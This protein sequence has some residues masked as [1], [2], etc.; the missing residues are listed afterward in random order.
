MVKE[1]VC[2]VLCIFWTLLSR[3]VTSH[4]LLHLHSHYGFIKAI[5]S[6]FS[7]TN[8]ASNNADKEEA[9]HNCLNDLEDSTGVSNEEMEG[10][11]TDETDRFVQLSDKT[12][13]D[14]II[15]NVKLNEW[16]MPLTCED[17][18]LGW[19]SV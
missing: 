13:V 7:K 16:L 15:A 9:D 17:V 12:V 8:K 11:D 10:V 5:L 19:F 3:Y 14:C 6:Q 2:I 18:N 1:H 4:T